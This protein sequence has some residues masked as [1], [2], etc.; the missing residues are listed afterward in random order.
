ML[1]GNEITD[2][3]RSHARELIALG[4]TATSGGP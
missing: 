4:M 3:S 2:L 1:A